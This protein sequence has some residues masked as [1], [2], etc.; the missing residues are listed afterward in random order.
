MKKA[1]L[2]LMLILISPATVLQAQRVKVISF[3]IRYDGAKQEDGENAWYY[4]SKAVINM[5][6]KEQP[7]VLGLQEALLD[8][9]SLIDRNFK[10]KYRRVGVG[11]DNGITRGEH[12]AI[13]YDN[14]KVDLVWH[15]T[16]WLSET[17]KRVSKGWDA[18]CLRTVTI[19]MFRH[20]ETGKTFYYFNTHLDHVGQIARSE[21]IKYIAQLIQNL[22]SGQSPVI[23]G[24]DMNSNL[25]S[26]IFNPLYD[27]G[28]NS[29][30]EVAPRTDHKN[31]YNAFGKNNGAIIDHFLVLNTNVLRYQT[32]T[33][34]YGVP[35]ISDHYPISITIEL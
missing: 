28:F 22:S 18:A 10:K 29:A 19:A 23:V 13:Y 2:I 14:T 7:V 5:I 32:I 6:K 35:F 33:R 4:R 20:R 25:D 31:T 27:L 26:E 16:R 30:R 8:Q 11:R 15:K 24:G 34:G 9:L 21:S 3:N 12:M 17:P 1:L